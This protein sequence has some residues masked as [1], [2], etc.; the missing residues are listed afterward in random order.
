MSDSSRLGVSPS[1]RGPPQWPWEDPV[2]GHSKHS[3]ESTQAT[4]SQ[5]QCWWRTTHRSPA[6]VPNFQTWPGHRPVRTLAA[7]CLILGLG[8]SCTSALGNTKTDRGPLGEETE[9][10]VKKPGQ[11]EEGFKTGTNRSTLP[12]LPGW[13]TEDKGERLGPFHEPRV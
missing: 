9:H 7:S 6:S 3:T 10:T 1:H 13:H 11:E 12:H 2:D 5:L 4:T 8:R